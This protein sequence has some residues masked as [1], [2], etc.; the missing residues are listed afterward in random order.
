MQLDWYHNLTTGSPGQQV[1]MKPKEEEWMSL[2]MQDCRIAVHG[3]CLMSSRAQPDASPL[4][5]RAQQGHR[6][7][8]KSQ[9]QAKKAAAE[10][11]EE[12]RFRQHGHSGSVMG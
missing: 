10:K 7:K 6:L 9:V 11:K 5:Q 8:E 3:P 2:K 4:S 1:M 12:E